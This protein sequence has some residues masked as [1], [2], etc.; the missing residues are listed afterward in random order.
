MLIIN[1]P[2][3]CE[4]LFRRFSAKELDQD[5]GQE[6]CKVKNDSGQV[7][8]TSQALAFLEVADDQ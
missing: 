8:A 4:P 3:G 6:S 1:I 2:R 5:V 7:L